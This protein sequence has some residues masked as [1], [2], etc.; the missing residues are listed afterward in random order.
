MPDIPSTINGVAVDFAPAVKRNVVQGVIDAL[1]HVIHLRA[2]RMV[3]VPPCG[4]GLTISSS[5][6]KPLSF[7]IQR[8]MRL[9]FGAGASLGAF[10]GT[11]GAN[12]VSL[13]SS[14]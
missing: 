6:M 8:A 12:S 4:V 11:G 13:P 9:P 10:A 2:M 3:S 1:R 7:A 14:V 5:M